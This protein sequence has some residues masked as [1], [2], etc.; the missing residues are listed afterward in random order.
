MGHTLDHLHVANKPSLNVISYVSGVESLFEYTE[1]KNICVAVKEFFNPKS[2]TRKRDIARIIWA[3]SE[4][5]EA[6][7]VVLFMGWS[8]VQ[9][10][11]EEAETQNLTG[12]AFLFKIT[13][14]DILKI[15]LKRVFWRQINGAEICI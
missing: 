7:V 10:V 15:R 8:H 12:K 13:T 4:K 2:A 5:R 3:L 9:W 14:L 11:L 1:N 6:T